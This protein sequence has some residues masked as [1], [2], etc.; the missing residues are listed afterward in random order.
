MIKLMVG[1]FVGGF[2]AVNSPVGRDL[3]ASAWV[4][5]HA[6]YVHLLPIVQDKAG[7]LK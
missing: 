1:F 5:V 6:V 3:F 2:F 4:H 7:I